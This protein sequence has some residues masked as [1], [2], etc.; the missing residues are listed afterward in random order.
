MS[1]DLFLDPEKVS[2]LEPSEGGP[3][4]RVMLSPF[5]VPRTI[6]VEF[7]DRGHVSSVQFH[8]SGDE[9]AGPVKPLDSE[10]APRVIVRISAPSCRVVTLAFEPAIGVDALASVSKRLAAKAETSQVKAERLSYRMAA[11]II[12]DWVLPLARERR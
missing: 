12:S 5:A 10:P 9:A 1:T 4:S 11:I 8:Y 2:E 6:S 7:L 3:A